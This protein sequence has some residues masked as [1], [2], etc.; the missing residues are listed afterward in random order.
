MM[1]NELIPMFDYGN[2]TDEHKSIAKE[3][4]VFLESSNQ[5]QLADAI[6]KRFKVVETPTFDLKQSKFFQEAQKAGI[7]VAV[8]GFVQEGLDGDAIQYQLCAVCEDVRNLDK[9]IDSV[10]SS[11]D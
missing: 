11:K 8:Q 9:F 4:A 2:I 6:R 5:H 7:F 10:K 1:T 3:I